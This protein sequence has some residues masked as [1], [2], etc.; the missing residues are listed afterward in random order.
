VAMPKRWR[1]LRR[2]GLDRLTPVY[3]TAQP[4]RGVSG[5]MR[6]L[7]YTRPE[8]EARH[9]ALLLAADRVDVLEGR[10]GELLASPLHAMGLDAVGRAVQRNPMRTLAIAAG[11]LILL[12]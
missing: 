2:K 7:A 1:K 8:H 12:R 11:A 10:F 6:R 3:G 5:L 9:W 4:P